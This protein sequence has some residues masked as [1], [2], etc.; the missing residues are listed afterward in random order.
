MPSTGSSSPGADLSFFE[1]VSDA[2]KKARAVVSVAWG[3]LPGGTFR[4]GTEDV[5]GVPMRVFKNLPSGLGEY[6][7]T[8]FAKF[9]SNVWLIYEGE[10]IT[11]AEAERQFDALGAELAS[12]YG[13]KKGDRVGICMRN[14]PEFLISFFGIT[15][16]GAVAVPLNALWKTDELKYAITDAG[17]KVVISDAE[18]TRRCMPFASKLGLKFVIARSEVSDEAIVRS[19]G[20]ALWPAVIAAGSKKPIPAYPRIH[21]DDEAMIMYTSGSTGF[22]KESFTRSV[23][24]VLP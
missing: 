7:R 1:R 3:V 15:A 5:R 6:Y 23:L 22:P 13:I 20:A 8:W 12:T 4:F 14:Y 21:P 10:R 18:R 16:M 24:W 9:A 19:S 2:Y 11:F 17:C